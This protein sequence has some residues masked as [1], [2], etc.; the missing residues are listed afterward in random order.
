M[1]TASTIVR[2]GCAVLAWAFVFRYLA[3]D[4]H[5]RGVG[6][7]MMGLGLVIAVFMSLSVLAAYGFRFPHW[8]PFVLYCI[9]FLLLA[10]LHKVFTEE[11]RRGANK[12][13]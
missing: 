13:H 11:Q 5:D 8:L 2:I 9:L 1:Q 3:T 12:R 4:W 6:R 7:V 10:Y